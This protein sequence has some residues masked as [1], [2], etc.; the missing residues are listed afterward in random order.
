M[1]LELTQ[2]PI[3]WEPGALSLVVKRPGHEADHSSPSSAEVK[4]VWTS[5][6]T[7]QYAFMTWCPVKAQG[8]LYLYLLL[9]VKYQLL[10]YQMKTHYMLIVT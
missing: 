7:P 10:I 6:S 1:A 3:Q 9:C 5:T 4:N 2:P 8:Q